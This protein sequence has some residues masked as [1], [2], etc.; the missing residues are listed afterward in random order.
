MQL[1]RLVSGVRFQVSGTARISKVGLL[2][3][4]ASPRR[5]GLCRPYSVINDNL[6]PAGIP[7]IAGPYF[8]GHP[9]V[10]PDT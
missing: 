10:Q 2:A 6:N 1:D 7:L 3:C 5:G 8:Y 4:H 9:D